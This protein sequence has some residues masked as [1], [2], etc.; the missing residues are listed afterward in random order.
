VLTFGHSST[1]KPCI[2]GKYMKTLNVLI[3]WPIRYI[4]CVIIIASL[5]DEESGVTVAA[6]RIAVLLTFSL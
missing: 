5:V 4:K 3:F 1:D 6:Q 2:L